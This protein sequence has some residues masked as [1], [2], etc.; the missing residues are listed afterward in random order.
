MQK[1]IQLATVSYIKDLPTVKLSDLF[2]HAARC[3]HSGRSDAV[4]SPFELELRKQGYVLSHALNGYTSGTTDH[5]FF[6]PNNALISALDLGTCKITWIGLE[7]QV[8]SDQC[9]IE[10][11]T[12]DGDPSCRLGWTYYTYAGFVSNEDL[13]AFKDQLNTKDCNHFIEL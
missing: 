9:L 3:G 10:I 2:S 4:R 11:V 13:Q 5:I 7:S 6:K 12:G 8:N 1:V